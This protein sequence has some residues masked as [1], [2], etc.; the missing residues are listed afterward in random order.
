MKTWMTIIWEV[1]DLFFV[2]VEDVWLNYRGRKKYKSIYKKH[3]LDD[4]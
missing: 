2:C 4:L 3:G 1:E